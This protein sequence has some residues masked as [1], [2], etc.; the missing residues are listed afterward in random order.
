MTQGK[1]VSIRDVA[2]MAGVSTATVSRVINDNG[3]F[4]EATRE[5]VERAIAESGYVANMAAKS[6]RSQRSYNIGMIVP[7]IS[8]DFFSAIA[9][10]VERT[11]AASGYSVFVCNTGNSAERERAYFTTLTSKLVDGVLCISGL[12]ELPEN[13]LPDAIPIVCIDRYPASGRRIPRVS[14]DDVRASRLAVE[15]LIGQGCRRILYISS[16][17]ADYARQ[18]RATGYREA[19]ASHGMAVRPVDTLFVTGTRPSMEEA[20]E[21]VARRIA[22]GLDFDGIFASSDHTAVGALKALRAAGVDVPGQVRIVGYD[23]SIYT[24]LTTPQLS[25]IQ[26][27]TDQLAERGCE[28]LLQMLAGKTPPAVTI[29]PTELVVRESSSK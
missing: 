27:H 18:D 15:H 25:T 6:L 23:D 2:R 17:T 14:S 1:P 20:E 5:R 26:R 19:L 24:R 10:H 11:L 9:L 13:L 8:N 7:D 29:V 22:Q 3:R 16:Y 12:N 28:V 21:L 4:S